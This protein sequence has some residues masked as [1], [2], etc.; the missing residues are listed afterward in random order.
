MHLLV[1]PDCKP[2]LQMAIHH[3][4]SSENETLIASLSNE[5]EHATGLATER[6]LMHAH[7]IAPAGP[8]LN[9]WVRTWGCTWGVRSCSTAATQD[10]KV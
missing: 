7:E 9:H 1:S 10:S 8:P 4:Q 5:A 2:N 3:H 6:L